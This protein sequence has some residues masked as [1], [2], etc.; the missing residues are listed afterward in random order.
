MMWRGNWKEREELPQSPTLT[1]LRSL[2]QP[3]TGQRLGQP[4][5][6]QNGDNENL[7]YRA[8]RS[9]IT[10]ALQARKKVEQGN[11]EHFV[12]NGPVVDDHVFLCFNKRF[13]W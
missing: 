3:S 13:L 8:S 9:K 2:S 1:S 10:P 12:P 7:V 11:K 4:I 6:I 5:T